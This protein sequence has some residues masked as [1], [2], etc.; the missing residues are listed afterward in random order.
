MP[1][2]FEKCVRE[3]GRVRR[4]SGPNKKYK[5]KKGEYMNICWD[6][7][8]VPHLGEVHKKK[9]KTE[10]MI[11]SSDIPKLTKSGMK[12]INPTKKKIKKKKIVKKSL[13]ITD[14]SII[15]KHY[16]LHNLWKNKNMKKMVIKGIITSHVQIINEFKNRKIKHHKV[17]TL[18]WD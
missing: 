10:K 3:K 4:I 1:K 2:A 16:Y 8:N 7:K 5:L 15:T 14:R 12:V 11:T 17:D 6:K 18:D 13:K 9:K